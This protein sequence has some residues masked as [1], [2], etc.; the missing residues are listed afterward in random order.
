MEYLYHQTGKAIQDSRFVIRQM[1]TTDVQVAK[2][3]GCCKQ[4]DIGDWTVA[5]QPIPSLLEASPSMYAKYN[6][7]WYFQEAL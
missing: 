3:E 5:H 7:A 4:E 2:S 6:S 1:E